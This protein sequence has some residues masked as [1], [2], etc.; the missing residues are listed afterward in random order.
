MPDLDLDPDETR[1][2][3]R[4]AHERQGVAQ[5]LLFYAVVLAPLVAFAVHGGREEDVDA[6]L[7]AFGGILL[8]NVWHLVEQ[9]RHAKTYESLF[10][11]L[12]AH[13][14]ASRPDNP[15]GPSTSGS[16]ADHA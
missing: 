16:A 12:S 13:Q 7:V 15:A 9:L 4:M 1:F 10:R 3:E 14:R 8:F 5:R 6:V 2:V 11:K